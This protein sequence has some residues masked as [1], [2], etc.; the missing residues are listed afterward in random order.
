M[1]HGALAAEG[2]L[3]GMGIPGPAEL[4][5]PDERVSDPGGPGPQ[6]GYGFSSCRK[7]SMPA[8]SHAVPDSERPRP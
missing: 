6:P 3:R 4:A 8:G 2:L 7:L 5:S 1:P